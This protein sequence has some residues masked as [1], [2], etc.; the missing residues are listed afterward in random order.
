MCGIICILSKKSKFLNECENES[1][2]IRKEDYK[3]EENITENVNYEYILKGITNILNRGY[4]S[5]SLLSKN[6][7]NEINLIK[8]ANID[9]NAYNMFLNE[10]EINKEKIMKCYLLMA[11]TRW[12][13]HGIPSELNAHPHYDNEKKFYLIHNG[14]I[15]NYNKIKSKLSYLNFYSE[16]DTEVVVKYISEEY[17]KENDVLKSLKNV[18]YNL[19]GT[20]AFILHGIE[21]N[22]IYIARNGSPLVIG[23]DQIENNIVKRIAISSETSG[24]DFY[25]TKK[26]IIPEKF[27]ILFS[28]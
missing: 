19:E 17:K 14:I 8:K 24:F 21:S 18:C 4:D 13:T 2:D 22:R 28:I 27:T 23:I 25:C 5:V 15:N 12:A 26:L 11:H 16:T 20:W 6:N 7:K 10:I 9:G 1:I 3:E